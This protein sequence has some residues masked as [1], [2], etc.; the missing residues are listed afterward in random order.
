M[1]PSPAV[2]GGQPIYPPTSALTRYSLTLMCMHAY[3]V[4][5]SIHP[6]LGLLEVLPKWECSDRLPIRLGWLTDNAS[7][8]TLFHDNKIYSDK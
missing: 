8:T 3:V 2:V 7:R 1:H 6:S 5:S 4:S